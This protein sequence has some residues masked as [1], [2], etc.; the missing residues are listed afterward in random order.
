MCART[1][2][3]R[4]PHCAT[5][6]LLVILVL[7][8]CCVADDI[9]YHVDH[10]YVK[11]WINKDGSIDLLYDIKITCDQGT[12]NHV[13]VGQPKHDFTIGYAKDQK[14]HTLQTADVSEGNNFRARVYLDTPIT[15]TQSIQFTLLTN[16]GHSKSLLTTAR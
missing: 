13:N 15:A 1:E 7:V 11:I 10:E 6:V 14:N 8:A 2:I 9:Q 5:L 16:V 3:V 4:K 12:I